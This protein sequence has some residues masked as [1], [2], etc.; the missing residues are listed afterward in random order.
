MESEER[1]L[2]WTVVP[3]MRSA[4]MIIV[5]FV[6]PVHNNEPDMFAHKV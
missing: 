4:I 6:G 5:S 2:I 1:M 3:A